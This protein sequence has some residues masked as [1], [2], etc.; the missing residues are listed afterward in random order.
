MIYKSM[1][2]AFKWFFI[3]YFE[4]S[5]HFLR[6]ASMVVYGPKVSFVS[7]RVTDIDSTQ[8]ICMIYG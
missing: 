3:S 5:F 1:F 8:S 7:G 4:G 2:K 6:V